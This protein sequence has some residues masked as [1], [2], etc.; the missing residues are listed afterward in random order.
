MGTLLEWTQRSRSPEGKLAGVAAKWFEICR[1]FR[2]AENKLLAE[3]QP[4]LEARAQHRV[5]ISD[6]IAEGELLAYTARQEG[7]DFNAVGFTVEDVEAETRRLRE[8]Y[9]AIHEPMDRDEA[10]QI[11]EAAFGKG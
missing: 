8:S 5:V 3:R 10:N 9:T 7:E 11:L 4:N 2:L 1:Y 6:L